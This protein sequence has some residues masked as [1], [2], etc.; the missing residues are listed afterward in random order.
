ML[1][2][3]LQPLDGVPLDVRGQL[4]QQRPE[5]RR[6]VGEVLLLHSRRLELRGDHQPAEL[7]LAGR[8]LVGRHRLDLYPRALEHLLDGAPVHGSQP[9]QH[10]H[11]RR[12]A[13]LTALDAAQVREGHADLRGDRPQGAPGSLPKLLEVVAESGGALSFLG[14][15]RLRSWL[16]YTEVT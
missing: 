6:E 1:R 3:P 4:Q 16:G 5:R 12:P 11:G 8:E 14:H 10:R 13:D 7:L 9:G 2:L 15:R